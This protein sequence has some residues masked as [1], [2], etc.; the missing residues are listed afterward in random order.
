MS[1]LPFA[2]RLAWRESRSPRRIALLVAAVSAGVAALVAIESFTA[3]L[4]A[5]VR[6][7]SQALLGADLAMGSASAFSPAAEAT[8]D[9]IARAGGPGHAAGADDQLLGHGLRLA[10]RGDAARAGGGGGGRIPVLRR[11][12]DRPP[13]RMGAARR[14]RRGGGRPVAA[15]RPRREGR[16][17]PLARRRA[18]PDPRRGAERARRRRRAHGVRIARV[19]GRPRRGGDRPPGVRRP[20]PLR[21]V[22][23]PAR[24]GAAPAPRR[25]LQAG[26]RRGA[27][28]A[29]APSPRTRSR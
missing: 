18:V 26:P 10:H 24:L 14:G 6:E 9:A 13:G 16:R 7:Q 29:C 15:P 20:R 19:H 11:D 21:G 5:S 22:P 17:R 25:S 4:Q 1:A 27:G 2:A 28:H 3:N 12:E 23:A 8:L